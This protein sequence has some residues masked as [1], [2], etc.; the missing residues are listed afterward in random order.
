MRTGKK[1]WGA[2]EEPGHHHHMKPEQDDVRP[3]EWELHHHCWQTKQQQHGQ[4]AEGGKGHAEAEMQTSSSP[5]WSGA[6]D[7]QG[8]I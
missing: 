6:T 4:T 3:E 8:H 1:S 5:T 2:G 7:T